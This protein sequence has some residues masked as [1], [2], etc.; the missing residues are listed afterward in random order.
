MKKDLR[1]YDHLE[2]QDMPDDEFMSYTK[3]E[4]IDFIVFQS[5]IIKEYD[6]FMPIEIAEQFKNKTKKNLISHIWNQSIKIHELEMKSF[7]E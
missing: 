5:E 7:G 6:V 1:E 4:L 2:I 3:Q